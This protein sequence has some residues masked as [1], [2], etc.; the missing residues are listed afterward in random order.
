VKRKRS[1]LFRR[2]KSKSIRILNPFRI[3]KLAGLVPS[4]SFAMTAIGVLGGIVAGR[5]I[6][7]YYAK[8]PFLAEKGTE[9]L[10]TTGKYVSG[11]L[12]IALGAML[13]G[14]L[15]GE[16]LKGVG[17]GIAATGVLKL[18]NEILPDTMKEYLPTL[19]VDLSADGLPPG[20]AYGNVGNEMVRVGDEMVSVGVDLSASDESIYEQI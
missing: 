18:A 19:G 16:L 15:K 10:S 3:P 1:R 13:A 7:P 5:N 20:L 17:V 14:K 11:L 9:T 2:S 6:M 8:I 4:K 12:N